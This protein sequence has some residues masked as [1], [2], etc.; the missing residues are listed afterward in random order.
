[1]TLPNHFTYTDPRTGD[2]YNIDLDELGEFLS[3][4]RYI[5]RVGSNPLACSTLADI[6]EPT[7]SIIV[8][9]IF[10]RNAKK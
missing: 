7:R 9:K 5:D 2:T 1:M 10:D 8:K 4:V 6:P 3:A